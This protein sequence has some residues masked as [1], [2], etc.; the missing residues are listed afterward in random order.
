[1][2]QKTQTLSLAALAGF[3]TL[4]L[5]LLTSRIHTPAAAEEAPAAA[6]KGSLAGVVVVVDPGHGGADPG[7]TAG[8]ITEAALTY[9]LAAELAADLQAQDA[10][11]VFTVRSRCLD[12]A[13]AATEAPPEPPDDAALAAT[14]ARL[15]SRTS[16]RPLW[17]RAAAAAAV[18]ETRRRT[19]PNAAR[20]VFFV[21]LHFDQFSA[22]A[23]QGGLVCVDKR[24][25]AVPALALAL[26]GQMQ[27]SHLCRREDFH[28][29]GGISGRTLGV[30]DPAYNPV[31]E[32]VLVEAAT[33]SNPENALEA[34]DP[35][36]RSELVREITLAVIETHQRKKSL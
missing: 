10:R 14:G 2:R 30:L 36:W 11:V 29:I 33:L 32:R 22:E 26:A 17:D 5:F 34:G 12:P 8:P 27:Q 18:W 24:S 1:M 20:N 21:S 4:G 13:L 16:P 28:G 35:A 23:V 25:G 3:G 7:T 19:D 31:P 9:R 15:V 6:D